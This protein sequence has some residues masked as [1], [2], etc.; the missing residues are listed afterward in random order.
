MY[1]KAQMRPIQDIIQSVI[2]FLPFFIFLGFQNQSNSS[3]RS[4]SHSQE[5]AGLVD[6]VQN[7]GIIQ[8]AIR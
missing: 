3:L 8:Q 1:F 2:L 5:M 6:A 4:K 7:S